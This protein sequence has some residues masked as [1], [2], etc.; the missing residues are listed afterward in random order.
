MEILVTGLTDVLYLLQYW[1]DCLQTYKG[2]FRFPAVQRYIHDLAGEMGEQ[3][4]S[5]TSSLA[6][7]TEVGGSTVFAY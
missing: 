2:Q 4:D 7:F 3:L 5:I 1:A 6:Y